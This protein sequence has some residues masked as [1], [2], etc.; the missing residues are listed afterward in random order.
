M[1]KKRHSLEQIIRI[2]RQAE[3]LATQGKKVPKICR[4]IG[5]SDYSYFTWRKMYG[6][7]QVDHCQ[8]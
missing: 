1:G 6:E 5:I 8:Q 3:V 2:L 7:I 4:E